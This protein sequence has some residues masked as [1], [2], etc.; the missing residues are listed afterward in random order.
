M[1]RSMQEMALLCAPHQGSWV[2]YYYVMV[3]A[4]QECAHRLCAE[5]VRGT[6]DDK[7]DAAY[8][9]GLCFSSAKRYARMVSSIVNSGQAQQTCTDDGCCASLPGRSPPHSNNPPMA[10]QGQR[11]A[12]TA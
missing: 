6:K 2:L 7:G 3:V 12:E 9:F 4:C 8:L 11:I 10:P 5:E 1:A